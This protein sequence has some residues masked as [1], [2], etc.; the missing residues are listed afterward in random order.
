M[1]IRTDLALEHFPDGNSSEKVH[2]NTHKGTF[3]ITEITIDDDS[4][5][6]TIGKGKGRYVTL[7]GQDL[8]VFSGSYSELQYR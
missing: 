4:C 6:E 2:I 5:I 7:E 8:T 1:N 3:S